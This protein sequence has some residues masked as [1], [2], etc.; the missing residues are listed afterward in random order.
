MFATHVERGRGRG[1]RLGVWDNEGYTGELRMWIVVL[2]GVRWW[3]W[4]GK[5]KVGREWW[6]LQT[7]VCH[8]AEWSPRPNPFFSLSPTPRKP[9][10]GS[11]IWN[12]YACSVL[13]SWFGKVVGSA[14]KWFGDRWLSTLRAGVKRAR[15]T[16][17]LHLEWQNTT[18]WPAEILTLRQAKYPHNKGFV[19]SFLSISAS[20]NLRMMY[21]ILSQGSWLSGL[22]SAICHLLTRCIFE[23]ISICDEPLYLRPIIPSI[24]GPSIY[25][26]AN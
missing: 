15:V 17:P 21:G 25:R 1:G 20:H 23:N 7:G 12:F 2:C 26:T 4:K 18:E 16:T 9:T 22:G 6:G 13:Y 19:F 24:K 5:Q 10:Q 3:W 8:P 11:C 14:G